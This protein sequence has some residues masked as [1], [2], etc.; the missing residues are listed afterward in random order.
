MN[1]ITH[2]LDLEMVYTLFEL[3]NFIFDVLINIFDCL[4]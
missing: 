3:L 2:V 1:L 4:K